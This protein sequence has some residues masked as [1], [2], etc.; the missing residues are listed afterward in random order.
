MDAPSAGPGPGLAGGGAW[1]TWSGC[2]PRGHVRVRLRGR[3]LCPRDGQG[4]GFGRRTAAPVCRRAVARHAPAGTGDAE[5]IDRAVVLQQ[6]TTVLAGSGWLS[7]VPQF[8]P[9]ACDRRRPAL[10]STAPPPQRR[11]RPPPWTAIENRCAGSGDQEELT[12]AGRQVEKSL[13]R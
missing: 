5:A 1:Q 2:A 10:H 6:P 7:C 13:G 8:T 9:V 3:I 11:A 4:F 12:R